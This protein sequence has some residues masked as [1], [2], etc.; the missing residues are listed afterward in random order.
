MIFPLTI[1][2][3][4]CQDNFLCAILEYGRKSSSGYL[5]KSEEAQLKSYKILWYF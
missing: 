4:R 5:R 1:T 3:K 2:K